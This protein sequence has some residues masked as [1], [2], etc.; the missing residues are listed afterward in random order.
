MPTRR[1]ENI[2]PE[3]REKIINAAIKE[4][5]KSGYEGAS[6]NV[7]IRDAEISKGSLYYYFEDKT[8]LYLTVIKYVME[9]IFKEV[10]GIAR[11]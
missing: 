8:D 7:I 9:D 4:F 3:R 11:G 2:D 6:L 5:T 10:G 1:F